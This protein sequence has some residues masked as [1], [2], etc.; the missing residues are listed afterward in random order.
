MLQIYDG[1]GFRMGPAQRES[2][3]VKA[4]HRFHG[5]DL[6][7]RRSFGSDFC[8]RGTLGRRTTRDHLRPLAH[9]AATPCLFYGAGERLDSNHQRPTRDEKGTARL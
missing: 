1:V 3:S 4:P 8:R 9:K 7:L 5:G 6:G 2:K